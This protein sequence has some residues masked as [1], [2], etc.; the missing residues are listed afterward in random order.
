[1]KKT[2]RSVSFLCQIP[3]THTVPERSNSSS[4]LPQDL[5]PV[6]R[7]AWQGTRSAGSCERAEMVFPE[8]LPFPR[9]PQWSA[10][11]CLA[12]CAQERGVQHTLCLQASRG[13]SAT[14]RHARGA[15]AGHSP[16]GCQLYSDPR[17]NIIPCLVRT[18][19]FAGAFS[20][21]DDSNA[22]CFNYSAGQGI[23][24]LSL[25]PTRPLSAVY[26]L[27]KSYYSGLR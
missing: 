11:S 14:R 25:E 2:R 7:A 27:C 10:C 13:C 18:S 3:A 1:M 12:V 8:E 19:L 20:A 15:G 16:F 6:A 21:A 22:A 24:S 23:C 9:S 4:L 26:L 5:P 17:G